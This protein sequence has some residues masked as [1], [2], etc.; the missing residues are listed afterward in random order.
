MCASSEKRFGRVYPHFSV[1]R[2]YARERVAAERRSQ[3]RTQPAAQPSQ[4]KVH[5]IDILQDAVNR[6][7][8]ELYEDMETFEYQYNV[9]IQNESSYTADQN[10]YSFFDLWSTENPLGTQAPPKKEERE[11]NEVVKKAYEG[12]E[13]KHAVLVNELIPT[14]ERNRALLKV[15]NTKKSQVYL[16]KIEEMV[17]RCNTTL[18]R[19]TRLLYSGKRLFGQE[20]MYT[21]WL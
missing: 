19:C 12:M 4:K 6:T 10:L 2:E 9:S 21:N 16:E 1:C 17:E 15:R 3:K 11:N 20:D 13:K 14:L 5:S 7:I 8:W 18:S